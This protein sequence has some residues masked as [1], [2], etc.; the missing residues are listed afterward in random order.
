MLKFKSLT[1]KFI[2]ISLIMVAV[3]AVYFYE[4]F[5]FT[6][7]MKGEAVRINIAGR[8][9][10]LAMKMMYGAKGMLDPLSPSEE[11]E[12]F[13]NVF[14]S[15][16]ADYEDVLY[17]MGG[18]N[19]K[20]GLKPLDEHYK[21]SISHLNTLVNLWQKT[22]KPVLLSIK[23]FPPERRNEACVKCHTA[24]RDKIK[25]IEA[26]VK[27]FEKDHE[28]DIKD[29]DVLRFYAFGF[30]IIAGGFIVFYI[31][32]S[33][34]K[35]LWRLKDAAKEIEKGDFNVRVDVKTG[36][37][38]GNLS[39][40]FND[41]AQSLDVTFNENITLIKRLEVLDEISDDI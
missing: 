19:E 25:N 21:D 22:Q 4:D 24:M 1:A 35:P 29:F 15:A 2:F 3:L 32:Q 33:I 17:S 30:F 5:R 8:Q 34:I 20:L 18:G 36:D 31:R 27:S 41:M 7:H 39:K 16:M 28:K 11:K 9:R 40:T 13:R 6:H 23:E 14:N 37:E 12:K 38:I 26:F 10:M